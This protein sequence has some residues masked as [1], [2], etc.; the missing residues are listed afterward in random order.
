[1]KI[2]SELFDQA[3]DNY[4][5]EHGHVSEDLDKMITRVIEDMAEVRARLEEKEVEL[6]AYNVTRD[7]FE[8]IM[9][10]VLTTIQLIETRIDQSRSIDFRQNLDLFKVRPQQR[11]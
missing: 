11:H 1:M 7:E 5:R 8:N 9:E 4:R 2:N 10:N 3:L 6:H